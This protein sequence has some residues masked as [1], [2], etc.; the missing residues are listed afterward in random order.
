MAE[1]K[2]ISTVD[3]I[4]KTDHVLGGNARIGDRRIAVWMLV[5]ARRLGLTDEE[6]RTR[7]RPPL[8]QAELDAAWHYHEAHPSEI[9]QAIMENEEA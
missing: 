2:V 5:Q 7:Y 3:V 9:E 4:R 1:S 6:I 8:K